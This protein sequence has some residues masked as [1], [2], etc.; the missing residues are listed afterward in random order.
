LDIAYRAGV[1]QSTVSRALR[2]SPLVNEKT[3]ERIKQIAREMN[4][5]VDHSAAVLR[6]QK[7]NTIALLLFE[8]PTS[9]D[10]QI[11]PFFLSMLSSITRAAARHGFDVLIS[12]QHLDD[13][14][15]TEYQVRN[16][17]EGIIL[18]GYGDYMAYRDKLR[19]LM[20]RGAHFVLWGPPVGDSSIHS[21]ASDNIRGT[22]EITEH[23]IGLGRRR[24]AFL[25]EASLRAP[26]FRQRYQGYLEALREAG[27]EADPALH[28]DAESSEAS[29]LKAVEKLLERGVDFD[30]IVA[31]SDLIAIGAIKCLRMNGLEVPGDVAVVGFDDIHAAAYF[32]P[33]LTTVRQDTRLAGERLV[34]HLL[35]IIEGQEVSPELLSPSLV[36]RSSC[37]RKLSR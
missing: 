28:V 5:R 7:S 34:T 11:N 27:L 25:G 18:L 23:L 17:A 29:G 35:A 30:A 2:D 31:A 24:L 8:D 4:Y 36:L 21:V 20:E 10:S 15:H 16:R 32:N 19:E 14:W 9:D 33:S 26:E 22:S 6:S 1:S 13:D 37:G 12:F 3:R